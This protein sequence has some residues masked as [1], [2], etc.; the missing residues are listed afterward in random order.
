MAFFLNSISHLVVST[1][2]QENREALLG[3][4]AATGCV[5]RQLPN[6]NPHP[7]AAQVSQ[8]EDSL[9]VRHDDGLDG[10]KLRSADTL[11]RKMQP[12]NKMEAYPDVLYGPGV[13]HGGNV[14]SIVDGDEESSLNM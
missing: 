5:Q 2:I 11:S 4:H 13:E 6:W 9:P 3:L 1:N 10:H 12:C 8:A 14:S 7:I